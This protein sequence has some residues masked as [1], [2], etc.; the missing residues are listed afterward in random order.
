MFDLTGKKALVTGATGGIGAEICR[1]LI[2]QGAIVTGTG[3]RLEK[4][5]ELAQEIGSGSFHPLAA[6]LS[7]P[8]QVTTIVPKAMELMGG[9][10]ILVNNAGIT[11]DGLS[12][13]MKEA[14]FDDVITVNLKVPFLLAQS[15]IMPMIRN[16]SGR[17]INI[18]SIVGVT[19]NPGQVNYCSAKAGL[20]GQS[21]SLAQELASRNI[22]VNVVAPGF[23]ATEMT[24]ILPSQQKEK[25]L[26]SIPAK[27]MGQAFDIAAAVTYLASDEAAYVT[28]QTLHINGGMAMI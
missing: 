1:M 5:Q 10:D 21:K 22:T 8:T 12:M 3:R 24:D 25:L 2:Q 7:D 15:C 11:K 20:I 18:S 14:D 19:G 17:I 4:L 26:E 13:R 9:I 28:G 16:K 6:D 27:R 23:I